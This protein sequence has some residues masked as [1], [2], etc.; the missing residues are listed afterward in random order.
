MFYLRPFNDEEGCVNKAMPPTVT[1]NPD[2][3]NL[4]I[5]LARTSLKGPYCP[6]V[7]DRSGAS[8]APNRVTPNLIVF[9]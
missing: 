5:F 8:H 2:G 9:L 7:I 6:D 3:G 4:L 1:E